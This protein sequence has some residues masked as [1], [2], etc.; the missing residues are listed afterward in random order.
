MASTHPHISETLNYLNNAAHVLCS[1]SPTT[2]AHLMSVHNG[3]VNQHGMTRTDTQRQQ[4]CDACG[5]ILLPQDGSIIRLQ[6]RASRPRVKRQ[7]ASTATLQH[8]PIK[9]I[10]CGF[11]SRQTHI[12]IQ[13]PAPTPASRSRRHV[14]KTS[15][16]KAVPQDEKATANAS[17]KKRAKNRKAGLQALL[18]GQQKSA[19]SSLSLADFM[20]K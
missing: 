13:T 1:S 5:H 6:E 18:S 8:R 9:V 2:S 12:Q 17:S 10:H 11:C 4:A 3:L 14:N 15:S 20:R 16:S 19:S 7:Q